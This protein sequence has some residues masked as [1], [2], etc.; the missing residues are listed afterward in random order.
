MIRLLVTADD[1]GASALR[2]NGILAAWEKGI[3]TG[4]SLLPQGEATAEALEFAR[5]K[6]LPVGVHLNLSE[7]ETISGPIGG[8]SDAQGRLP[9]KEDLRII[10]ATGDFDRVAL[11]RELQAQVAIIQ[12]A[13]L[14]ATHIDTHQHFFLF[15][16]IT[17]A[18]IITA[19]QS[20]INRLRLPMPMEEA[21]DDPAGLL[22]EE[23]A[24]YRQ[25]APEAVRRL[26]TAGTIFPQGLWGMPLLNRLDETSL[27]RLIEKLPEGIWELMVHPGRYDPDDPFAGPEREQEC[28][29][30]CSREIRRAINARGIELITYHQMS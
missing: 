5:G 19:R 6:G 20:G 25:L 11:R 24:L 28:Q 27:H 18:V 7:G 21:T 1:F 8:L 4:A 29:T 9:G 17:D 3:V 26:T 23:L 10:L 22:G 13:G 14:D 15:P 30:L 16:S 2:N 12:Q